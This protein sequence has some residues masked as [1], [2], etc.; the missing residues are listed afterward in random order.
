MG[1]TL[2]DA[3]STSLDTSA[4][5]R[6]IKQPSALSKVENSRPEDNTRLLQNVLLI[7]LDQNIDEENNRDCQK[8]IGELRRIV[9]SINTFTD[10]DQCVTFLSKIRDEKACIL[11]SGSLGRKTIPRMHDMSQVDSIF[12]FCGN[13]AWHEEWA[14]DWPK[15]KGIFNNISSVCEGLK[16]AAEQC[17]RN[18][19]SMSIV[20]RNTDGIATNEKLNQ[21]EPLFMYTQILKE[22]LLTIEFEQHHFNEFIDFCRKFCAQE[23][24]INN[25]EKFK[26]EYHNETPIWWYTSDLFLYSMLNRALRVMDMDIIIRMGFFVG[27]LHRHLQQ[28][29]NEQ[30][31]DHQPGNTFTVFRGQ[32]LSKAS[33][34]EIQ[35]NNVSH[36]S[37]NNF[38]STSKN[39]NVSMGFA[40]R[41]LSDKDSVGILF[42][43]TVDPARSTTPFASINDVSYYG[44]KEDEILFSMHTVFRIC[45]IIPIDKKPRLYQ[46]ELTLTN[47]TDEDRRALTDYIRERT[48]GST[49]WDRLGQLLLKVGQPEKA[50]QVYEILIKEATEESRKG[51]IYH[52]LGS[53]K[54]H[55]GKYQEAIKLYE[56]ALAIR[57]RTLP[58]DHPDLAM[59]YNN[60][61]NVY[62]T[63]R[64]YPKALVSHEKALEIRQQSLPPNHPDLAMSYDS[65]GSVIY[66]MNEYSQALPSHKKALKIRQ[67]SLPPNHPD[68]AMSY[69]YIGMV[70]KKKGDY[71]KA[72]SFCE[73]AVK[74]GECSLPSNHPHLQ[75]YKQNR[76]AVKKIL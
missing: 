27:D 3:N 63:M 70:Y 25:I 34:K 52:R 29:H 8:N 53:A 51:T 4:N 23:H 11:I 9:N 50:Q 39:R 73:E 66:C 37:F 12:I 60:I 46:V 47:N 57:K 61:G 21:L 13:I 32:G 55:Q 33:F 26:R 69:N 43:M 2:S 54:Y 6:T 18:A 41:A 75:T 7:W 30:F 62:S 24:E 19:I 59:S 42:V 65:I 35:E 44:D 10:A 49:G 74:I 28:L 20:S 72:L 45:N 38:L 22:I 14:K 56:E 71:S 64:M 16:E 40:N 58:S 31:G 5:R 36:I 68:L 76:D 67:Q 17:E 15:I 48:D 1:Q